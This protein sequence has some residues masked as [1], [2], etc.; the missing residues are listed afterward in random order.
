MDV[1]GNHMKREKDVYQ[2]NVQ[3][4]WNGRGKVH[5]NSI[6]HYLLIVRGSK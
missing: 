6:L 3:M 2:K 4:Y 1:A 5:L